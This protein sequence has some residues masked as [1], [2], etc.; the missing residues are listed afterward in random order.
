VTLAA[1]TTS[2]TVKEKP[3]EEDK[4]AALAREYEWLHYHRP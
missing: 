3:E 4:E 2:P 1:H